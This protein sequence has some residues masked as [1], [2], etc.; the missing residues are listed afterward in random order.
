MDKSSREKKI[1]RTGILGM[2]ANFFL[3][4]FKTAVG[5]ISNS[6]SIVLDAVNNLTDSLSSAVT[7][8][9]I[10][11]AGKTPDRKHPFGYGRIEYFSA[12]IIAGIVL[13]A[14]I[15]SMVESIKK[16]ISPETPDYSLISLVIVFIAVLI[17][18]FLGIHFQKVGKNTNS[19]S[20]VNSGKDALMDSIISASTLITAIIFVIT[21]LALE[22]YLGVIISLL[23]IR[24]AISMLKETV[25][26]LLGESTSVE[27]AKQVIDLVCSEKEV[28]GAYDLV[29]NNYG[30]NSFR[31]SVHISVNDYLTADEIDLL[32]RR[33][34]SKVYE[35]TGIILNAIGI[36]S[37][38][39]KH[40]DSYEKEQLLRKN[41]SDISEITQVHGFY[42]D[43]NSKTVRFDVVISLD[44]KN[45][46]EIY[47]EAVKKAESLFNGYQITAVSD[48]SY[49]DLLDSKDF[50]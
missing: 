38:N 22:A 33:I 6:I 16:I 47:L 42:I 2:V 11:M 36:Y 4:G 34:T 1:V 41:L 7:I 19:E 27:T 50:K 49:T 30:P 5:L 24:T 3:A 9:G 23:I 26:E 12:L 25:S 14:G 29:L 15:S 21:G 28:D 46:N 13:Y 32:Q 10:K 44:C 48:I 31:G 39:T 35:K 43:V 45:R 18:I 37:K 20:L 17:K 40:D 8:I